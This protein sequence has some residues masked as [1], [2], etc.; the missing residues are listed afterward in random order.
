ML[1][2]DNVILCHTM[3]AVSVRFEKGFLHEIERA[4]KLHGY[5]TLTEFIRESVRDKVKNL[6]KEMAL[7]R[8]ERVYG[9]GAQKG[10]RI[11]DEK[12][13][14]AGEKAFLE[15]EKELGVR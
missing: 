7:M 2:N 8:L 12:V 10:R 6:K 13:H 5:A 1:I 4:M 14:K 3:E 15:L 9:S 11:T